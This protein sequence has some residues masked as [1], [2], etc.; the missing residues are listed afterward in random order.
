VLGKKYEWEKLAQMIKTGF[1][2][3]RKT[4][5]NYPLYQKR[6]LKGAVTSLFI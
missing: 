3:L 6:H 1:L 4:D 5:K 2:N